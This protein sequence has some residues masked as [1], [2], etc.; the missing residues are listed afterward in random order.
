MDIALVRDI[1]DSLLVDRDGEPLGRAD[2]IVMSWE[3]NAPPR[4]THLE[5]GALT[6]AHRLPRPWRGIVK[7]VALRL[8]LRENVPYRIEVR[9]IVHLGRNIEIDIDASRSAARDSERW[10]RDHVIARIPGN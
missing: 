10:I 1:L 2:G 8:T 4:V 3:A 5:L 6:L 9:R 7:W